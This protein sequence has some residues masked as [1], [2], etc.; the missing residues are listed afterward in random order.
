MMNMQVGPN[1]PAVAL[2]LKDDLGLTQEQVQGLERICEE[3]RQQAAQ[4]LT[5][6]QKKRLQ[7]VFGDQNGGPG[8]HGAMMK[9]GHGKSQK[10]AGRPAKNAN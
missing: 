9:A 8:M 1:D 10:P 2:T 3:A 7:A 6:A 5:E 4:L